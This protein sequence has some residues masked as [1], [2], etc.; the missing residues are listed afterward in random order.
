MKRRQK[1][2]PSNITVTVLESPEAIDIV[3]WADRYIT[4]LIEADQKTRRLPEAA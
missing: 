4:L 2:R 3:A 1:E